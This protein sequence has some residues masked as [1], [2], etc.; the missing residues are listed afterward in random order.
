MKPRNQKMLKKFKPVPSFQELSQTHN[1]I[2]VGPELKG[3]IAKS[4]ATEP[5]ED[6]YTWLV[7]DGV[8]YGLKYSWNPNARYETTASYK[9]NK[10]IFMPKGSVTLQADGMV[11]DEHT[12]GS[13][14]LSLVNFS[15]LLMNYIQQE[16]NAHDNA[17]GVLQQ[18]SQLGDTWLWIGGIQSFNW[19]G[20]SLNPSEVYNSNSLFY[21]VK[22]NDISTSEASSVV[23]KNPTDDLDY[24][25]LSEMWNLQHPAKSKNGV[26]KIIVPENQWDAVEAL[27]YNDSVLPLWL[28]ESGK[29]L[30][31]G[32]WAGF[33]FCKSNDSIADWLI[34]E[35][36]ALE[37]LKS[38]HTA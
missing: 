21:F 9:R 20:K 26:Y 6:Y 28:V 2:M 35:E 25:D 19:R 22:T 13:I 3:W 23:R 7:V 5:E 10:L 34:G 18:L 30:I 32:A 24:S 33:F 15:F 4:H 12:K 17:A 8:M 31:E 11:I 16:I 29:P 14:H 27:Y 36:I 37:D 38:I 1:P